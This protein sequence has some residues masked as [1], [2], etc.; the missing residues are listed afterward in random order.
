MFILA[1][2]SRYVGFDEVGS[3]DD[4]GEI[5][6]FGEVGE[7]SEFGIVGYPIVVGK[8]G[9]VNAV[10]VMGEFNEAGENGGIGDIDVF[11]IDEFG[12]IGNDGD[13]VEVGISAT[14][15]S[16]ARLL[17]LEWL[18]R[19]ARVWR[20]A[21]KGQINQ[22]DQNGEVSQVGEILKLW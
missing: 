8:I 17:M 22:E 18:M 19:L 3:F 15:A 16:W 5:R 7:V 4:V 2:L 20:L 11:D 10:G 1:R 12:E 9:E 13:V 14:I 6:E 21:V